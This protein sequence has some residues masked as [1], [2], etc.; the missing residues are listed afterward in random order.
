MDRGNWFADGSKN[1]EVAEAGVYRKNSDTNLTVPL[2]PHSI[3]LQTDIAVILQCARKVQ[4]HG[5]GRNIHICSDSRAAVTI[6]DES[7]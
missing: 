7:Q 1:R 5:H 4:D 2:G 6:L 3:V